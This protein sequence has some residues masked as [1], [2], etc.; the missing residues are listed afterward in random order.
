MDVYE[1]IAAR[2]TIRDFA[3]REIEHELIK[4][5]ITAGFKAPTNNHMREWHFVLLQDKARRKELLDRVIHPVGK[6]GSIGII[7]RWGLT[8]E[9]QREMYIEAI[10]RQYNMLYNAG[11][12]MLPCFCQPAPLLKPKDLSALNPFASIWCCIE[13][14]LLA[15][16]A[17]GIFGV[18]RIPAEAERKILKEYLNIPEGYE[19]PCYLALG[20]PAETAMRA[21]QVEIS[22][23]ERIHTDGW[24]F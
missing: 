12:L 18:T 3:P 10:P 20:Y 2:K 22:I 15:A 16:A 17:E 7:N 21:S 8:D 14:I 24:E 23:N 19:I 13:N 1:A 11:C 9:R 6:K 5:I 4:K